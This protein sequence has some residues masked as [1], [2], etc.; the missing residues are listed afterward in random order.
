MSLN[1]DLSVELVNQSEMGTF[2]YI[3][4]LKEGETGKLRQEYVEPWVTSYPGPDLPMGKSGDSGPA[5]V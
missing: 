2:R 4:E 3:L 1:D 5:W